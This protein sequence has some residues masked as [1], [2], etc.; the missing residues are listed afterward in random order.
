MHGWCQIQIF[1]YSNFGT[2]AILLFAFGI[3]TVTKHHFEHHVVELLSTK[4]STKISFTRNHSNGNKQYFQCSF[5]QCPSR[6]IKTLQ[7]GLFRV[8]KP[9]NHLADTNIQDKMHIIS[10]CKSRA[11]T[12]SLLLRQI[13]H[14]E[15]RR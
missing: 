4:I 3:L 14:E 11:Q 7:I 13:F 8:T 1:N 5:C 6:Q 12:E 2:C 9:H 15:C 10:S